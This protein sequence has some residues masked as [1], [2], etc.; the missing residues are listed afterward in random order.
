MVSSARVTRT[1]E[2][3]P[4]KGPGTTRVTRTVGVAV[5]KQAQ[6]KVRVLRVAVQV[7]VRM[8]PSGWGV[9]MEENL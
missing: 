9:T 7:V 6:A 3:I 5:T 2:Q 1:A 4:T 8:P